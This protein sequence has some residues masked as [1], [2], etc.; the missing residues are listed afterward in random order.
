MSPLAIEEPRR[1]NRKVLKRSFKDA[2]LFSESSEESESFTESEDDDDWWFC[3]KCQKV[4]PPGSKKR[5]LTTGFNVI[6]ETIGFIRIVN[7]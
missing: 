4:T 6:F 7:K 5:S 2:F 1:S 3:A